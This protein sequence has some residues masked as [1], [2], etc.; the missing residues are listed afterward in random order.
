VS[1]WHRWAAWKARLKP[2]AAGIA[3]RFQ[4]DQGHV[5][6]IGPRREH[7]VPRL[8]RSRVQRLGFIEKAVEGHVVRVDMQ[9]DLDA[10]GKVI[11]LGRRSSRGGGDEGRGAG[12]VQRKKPLA[13]VSEPPAVPVEAENFVAVSAEWRLTA[14][15]DV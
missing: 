9:L 10:V 1:G 5:D 7:L 14:A 2:C 4:F 6:V 15:E 3:E 8:L 13:F 12:R 11:L